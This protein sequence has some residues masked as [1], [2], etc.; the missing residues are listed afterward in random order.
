MS[1]GSREEL[2]LA[3]AS[4]ELRLLMRHVFHGARAALANSW[5]SKDLLVAHWGVAANKVHVVHPGVDAERFH[6]DVD[7]GNWRSVYAPR[8]GT[9][10][11]SVGR[12]QR[13][14][15]HDLVLKALARW[16]PEDAGIRYLIAGDGPCRAALEEEARALGVADKVTFLGTV[17]EGALPAL[18][19]ACD[20]FLMPNRADGVD[21][22]GFGIVFLEAAASGRPAIGGRSGGVPEAVD[23]GVTGAVGGE[24]DE[25]L[26]LRCAV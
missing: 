16:R 23:D 6:P 15:G 20:V 5:N 1:A 26:V 7:P 14:K 8:G 2:G 17:D 12:L 21:F 9:L 3:S 22:E 10:F 4:R 18:Y 25:E 24:D 11:L 19:A 13:R